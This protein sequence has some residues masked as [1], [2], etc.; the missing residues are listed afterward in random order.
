MKN[1]Y[2]YIKLVSRILI[3]YSTLPRK[4]TN[5]SRRSDFT[6]ELQCSAFHHS[7]VGG[8]CTLGVFAYGLRSPTLSDSSSRNETL[9]LHSSSVIDVFFQL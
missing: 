7:L 4:Y 9:K 3:G 1:Y 2:Y 8:G 6:L 5:C